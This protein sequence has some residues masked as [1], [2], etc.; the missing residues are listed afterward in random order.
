MDARRWVRKYRRPVDSANWTVLAGFCVDEIAMA[1]VDHHEI[2]LRVEPTAT[3]H[4]RRSWPIGEV[5]DRPL[6]QC[7]P[8]SSATSAEEV[9]REAN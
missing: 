5:H 1:A 7:T 2:A 9:K 6:I 8:G 3:V 4:L